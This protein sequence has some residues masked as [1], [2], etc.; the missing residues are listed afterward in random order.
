VSLLK[1]SFEGRR[2]DL[3]SMLRCL[4]GRRESV[5]VRQTFAFNGVVFKATGDTMSLT[6]KDT[7]VPGT[8]TV[9]VAF[10]DAKG[11]PAAVDGVPV[12][13]VDSTSVVDTITPAADG[14]SA[15]LHITDN[16]GA[17][18][19]TVDADADLGSGVTDVKVSDTVSV[20]A[21]DAVAGNFTFGA[22]TPDP[23]P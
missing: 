7:E 14:M 11:K 4:C 23:T 3:C 10:T 21:G 22:V 18:L 2:D 6:V 15:V 19:V 17:A 13:T 16:I 8:C 20:I 9:T 5:I 12:W 1:F